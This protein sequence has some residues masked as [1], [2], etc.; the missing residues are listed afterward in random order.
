MFSSTKEK[1]KRVF[2]DFNPLDASVALIEKPVIDWRS[3]ST[4][5]F[6]YEGNT[7]I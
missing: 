4:G 1:E 7:D 2:H 5:W 3:R 6:L